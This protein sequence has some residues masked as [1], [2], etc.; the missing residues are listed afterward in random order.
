MRTTVNDSINKSVVIGGIGGDNSVL[1]ELG[2]NRFVVITI[3][4]D[5]QTL[6]DAKVA[7]TLIEAISDFCDL[8]EP[9]DYF[10]FNMGN[11]LNKLMGDN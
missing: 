5:S 3:C 4:L 7:Q 1:M 11:S 9:T 6:T 8:F 2:G 10:C